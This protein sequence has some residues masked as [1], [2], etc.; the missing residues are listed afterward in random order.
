[1]CEEVNGCSVTTTEDLD[2][3][4]LSAEGTEV[5][6]GG[7]VVVT[8]LRK[9][10]NLLGIQLCADLTDW[11]LMAGGSVMCEGVNG[12]GETTTKEALDPPS[13]SAEGTVMIATPAGSEWWWFLWNRST[14]AE[15]LVKRGGES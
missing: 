6:G 3:L 1:M 10:P 15:V 4:S 8:H 5:I 14:S 9:G 2:P 7:Y 11:R 13:L 12:W